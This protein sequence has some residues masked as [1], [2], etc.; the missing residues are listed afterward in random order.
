M[1]DLI[2]LGMLLTGP[3]HGYR[4]KQQAGMVFGQGALHN[5]LVYPLLRRFMANKWVTK[6]TVPGER[7]QN[8]QQ[9]AITPLGRQ[10]LME[11]L[12]DF[13]EQDAHSEDAFRLRVG[14]FQML[15]AG[16]R[17]R[18]LELRE[19]ALHARDQVLSNLR[20]AMN[21]GIYAGEVV[22][23]LREQTESEL[24]WIAHLRRLDSKHEDSKHEK[25]K[26][27]EVC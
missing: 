7:G 15:P 13:S 26:A 20:N 14:F 17:E 27:N 22:G 18:I 3:Q 19:R 10:T 16:D 1:T 24:A 5:N 6:K 11:R 8:R 12:R 9:Y 4:L 25:E 21:L 2:I 23:F